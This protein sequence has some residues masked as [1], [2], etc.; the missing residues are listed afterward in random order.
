MSTRVFCLAQRN[1]SASTRWAQNAITVAGLTNGTAGSSLYSLHD[2]TEISITN[3]DTL[4]IVD[5]FNTRIVL[6]G[7]NST[8]PLAIIQN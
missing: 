2:N 4:Y 7:P 6:I 5:F 8:T 3:D 1:L